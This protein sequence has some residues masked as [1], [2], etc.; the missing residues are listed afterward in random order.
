MFKPLSIIIIFLAILS[1]RAYAISMGTVVK[2][3]FARISIDE[4]ARFTI[5]FWN[6]ED[7]DY[8]VELS[9]K[10]S[11][12]DWTVIIEPNNFVLNSSVG[13][14]YINLPY[15]RI[16]AAPINVIVKPPSSVGFGNY[17][18]II[19]ARSELPNSGITLSQERLFKF[20]VEVGNPLFFKETGKQKDNNQKEKQTVTG[21][22]ISLE[23]ENNNSN[24]FYLIIILI[25]ILASFLIYKYS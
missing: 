14:E 15:G 6:I 10:E 23:K 4:S 19:N 13:K 2:N 1:M 5:L 9:V 17:E 8:K 11:P 16:K 25:I 7:N 3:D 18:I 12:K 24:Y 22:S 20:V 21:E